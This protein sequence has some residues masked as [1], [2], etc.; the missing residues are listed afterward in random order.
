V[1]QLDRAAISLGDI[2][3]IDSLPANKT[4]AELFAE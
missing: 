3:C 4:R 1:K 2:A